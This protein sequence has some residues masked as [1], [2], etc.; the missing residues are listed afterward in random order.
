[1]SVNFPEKKCYITLEVEWLLTAKN[2][3]IT[4]GFLTGEN[5]FTSMRKLC[6]KII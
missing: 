1:M 5:D 2:I 6:K 3:L 4:R